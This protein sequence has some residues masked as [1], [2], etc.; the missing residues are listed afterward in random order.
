MIPQ[1]HARDSGYLFV[2]LSGFRLPDQAPAPALQRRLYSPD[3]DRDCCSHG[4]VS[5]G[6]SAQ[7]G[8]VGRL[9][10]ARLSRAPCPLPLVLAGSRISGS[11]RRGPCL[12]PR[13]RLLFCS[14][15][16]THVVH[17]SSAPRSLTAPLLNP[18]Y[19]SASL[20]SPP[21]YTYVSSAP[22]PDP[23]SEVP[24]HI[25]R[26]VHSS[27]LTQPLGV[28]FAVAP[29]I[30]VPGS[31]YSMASPLLRPAAQNPLLQAP[32][33][34]QPPGHLPQ[35]TISPKSQIPCHVDP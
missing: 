27:Q 13:P 28:I 18:A 20:P 10:S 17:F 15:H 19:A 8:T 9:P 26:L 3:A 33:F 32:D 29:I 1:S 35:S 34:S 23:L 30:L 12:A 21:T 31:N 25:Q 6:Q 22:R 16:P 5:G 14:P 24:G 2:G 11:P 4:P 7:P